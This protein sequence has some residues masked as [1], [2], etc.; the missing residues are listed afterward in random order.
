[1]YVWH[2]QRGFTLIEVLVAL[3]IMAVMAIMG[4]R[5]IQGLVGSQEAAQAH[6]GA[7]HA[8]QLSLEQ[9]H[10]DLNHIANTDQ[11]NPLLFDGASLIMLRQAHGEPGW[12]APFHVVAW[13][14]KEGHLWRW[15]SEALGQNRPI[16]GAWREAMLWSRATG[17]DGRALALLEADEW[18]IY[19]YRDGS[20]T[21][22]QSGPGQ[23]Q[24]PTQ[25]QIKE[26]D[27]PE[28]VR[29][30][31]HRPAAGRLPGWFTADWIS[32]TWTPGS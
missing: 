3:S 11:G 28:G 30:K 15:Q 29:L 23:T 14:L 16:T 8:V 7:T 4:W 6:Q 21:N 1:M 17:N 19:F 32:P 2:K 10:L 5:G 22:P 24:D 13:S 12:P 27:L 9:F 20:W 18:Q 31:L 26:Q 25:G